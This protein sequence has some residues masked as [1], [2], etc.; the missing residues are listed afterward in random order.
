[1]R[2]LLWWTTT[3]RQLTKPIP[4]DQTLEHVKSGVYKLSCKTCQCSCIG[5]TSCNPKSRFREHTRY[6]KNNDPS[7]TYTLHILN[8]R[9]EYGNI[10]DTRALLKRIDSPSLL[11]PYEQM[12]IQLFHHNSHLIQEQH[13]NEHNPMYQ[14]L[15]DN[16]KTS[17]PPWHTFNHSYRT[18]SL[19]NCTSC[20]H[21]HS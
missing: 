14:L 21:Q 15:Y 20:G 9:H 10:S 18:S 8:C 17:H 19:P 4:T 3:L 2:R 7:P 5:Q 1:M 11:L 12:Y 13:P 6:I 16:Y